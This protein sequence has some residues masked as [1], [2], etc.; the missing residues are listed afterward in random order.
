MEPQEAA[1]PAFWAKPPAA[2]ADPRALEAL[3]AEAGM[4]AVD[5]VPAGAPDTTAL[6]A[7]LHALGRSGPAASRWTGRPGTP[8][9]WR[10]RCRCPPTLRAH[11][12]LGRAAGRTRA[13][14]RRRGT[15]RTRARRTGRGATLRPRIE[16][17]DAAEQ[18][19][20]IQDYVR[21][22]VA[23]V[24][25]RGADDL[26]DLDRNLFD[27][28]VDSLILIDITARLGTELGRPVPSSSFIE[29][30]TIRAFT[31]HLVGSWHEGG[32]PGATAP[33]APRRRGGPRAAPRPGSD[34][35]LTCDGGAGTARTCGTR[36]PPGPG[37]PGRPGGTRGKR[38]RD[39]GQQA[40][41][42][43]QAAAAGGDGTARGDA[44]EGIAVV[45]LAGRYPLA[46]TP[47]ALWA[48]LRDGRHC[49][50]EVPP[51]RWDAAEHYAPDGADALRAHTKWGGF[52]A[53]V[54]K[55]DPLF[56]HIS[57]TVAENMDPQERLFLQTA[58]ETLEDAGYPPRTLGR[59]NPVGV[60]VGLMNSNYEWMG[61][62]A[63]ALGVPTDAHSDHWSLANRVSHVLDLT[64]PSMAIDTACSASLTAVHLACESLRRGECNA[65]IAGGVNLILHPKH[66]ALYS[67]RN[68]VSHD[69][70]CKSFGTGA[71]GFVAGEGVGAVLLSR[72]AARWPT[73]TG[74]T[75]SSGARLST[76]AARPSVT[77]SPAPPPRPR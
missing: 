55:F 70:R 30:P 17:A 52:L 62:E 64:G 60:F 28:D 29:Y 77:P 23:T 59:D 15:R 49:I 75:A 41:S 8:R 48:N 50:T 46:D 18:R 19:R 14:G 40:R 53:D 21:T 4:L 45:G 27:M 31:D 61:G 22:Q 32:E 38:G 58:W 39:H 42:A 43:G 71:D 66:L 36:G 25:G 20:I 33:R 16:A 11:P 57:P 76:P 63:A 74:S 35:G 54:D 67:R 44:D 2:E 69:D 26:P 65:A 6:E 13:V 3:L 56:F 68:M 9:S 12:A 34:G 37:G 7:L 5:A 47:D 72:C 51:E 24:L 1:D 73:A 10:A